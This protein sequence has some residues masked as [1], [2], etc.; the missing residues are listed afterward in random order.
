M[1]M[2]S[3]AVCA[4]DVVALLVPLQW[5]FICTHKW[6]MVSW[7]RDKLSLIILSCQFISVVDNIMVM[8][9]YRRKEMARWGYDP[10]MTNQIITNRS[11]KP[12]QKLTVY[13]ITFNIW[14]TST[15]KI[16]YT[17]VVNIPLWNRYCCQMCHLHHHLK[18]H[19]GYYIELV[20]LGME[21][22]LPWSRPMF[23][24]NKLI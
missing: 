10:H 6:S 20:A 13:S 11:N 19:Q 14:L 12:V 3:N 9:G 4:T 24:L 1:M 8:T 18:H 16:E 2:I 7:R 17:H 22:V 15:K 5:G 23:F 21:V